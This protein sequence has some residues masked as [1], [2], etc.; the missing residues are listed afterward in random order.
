[1]KKLKC[2]LF[3]HKINVY[4]IEQTR[5]KKCTRC[6][7]NIIVWSITTFDDYLNGNI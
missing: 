1:M 2:W 3:G 7:K 4:L 6:G 5:K